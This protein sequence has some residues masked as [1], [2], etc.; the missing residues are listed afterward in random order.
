M[1]NKILDKSAIADGICRFIIEAPKIA[2]KRKAGNFVVVR[3]NEYAERIPLTIV[4]SDL[5]RGSI[6]LI[7]QGVGK[8][9]RLLN[10]L[11][12]GDELADVIGPLGHPTPI[13]SFG[14]V[15]CVGG[16]VGTAEVLPIARAAKEAGNEVVSIIGARTH[17]LLILEDE[18]REAS[19]ELYVVTDDGSYERQGLVVDP[20]GD[21]IFEGRTFDVVYAIGPMPM[22]RAVADL[23]EP[24]NIKTLVS[25]NP[26]MI[27]GTGMCGGCR[28]VVDGKTRFACVDG[29]EFDAHQVD[30]DTLIRRN[31]AYAAEEK[32]ALERFE[33]EQVARFEGLV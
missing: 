28:V 26:I 19:D 3:A 14:S 31:R 20:L 11:N 30:F 24:Y 12:P 17:S 27:D 22:M 7:V 18:M 25:L 1:A 16:G 33:T 23:T 15:A 2:R 4:D 10:S 13:D 32:I 29:P 21:L 9:T 5:E 8:S 6:T